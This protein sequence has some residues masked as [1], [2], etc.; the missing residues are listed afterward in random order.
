MK[1]VKTETNKDHLISI[2]LKNY[3]EVSLGKIKATQAEQHLMLQNAKFNV[4]NVSEK[5]LYW[6]GL[7]GQS[8]SFSC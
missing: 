3:L 8:M 1:H 2:T 6:V 4:E 5:K 7:N